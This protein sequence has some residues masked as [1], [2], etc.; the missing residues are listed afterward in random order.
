[1]DQGST[2]GTSYNSSGCWPFA[3]A[4]RPHLPQVHPSGIRQPPQ[5]DGGGVRLGG[6]PQC[7]QLVRP[8]LHAGRCHR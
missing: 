3:L 5:T 2:M 8:L 6:R 7:E 4:R 1:M